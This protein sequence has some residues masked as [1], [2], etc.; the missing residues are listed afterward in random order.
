MT[1]NNKVTLHLQ[2]ARHCAEQ[3]I[4][5]SSASRNDLIYS[6]QP[7]QEGVYAAERALRLPEVLPVITGQDKGTHVGLQGHIP[8]EATSALQKRVNQWEKLYSDRTLFLETEIWISYLFYMSQ[9]FG[10][11][12]P[13][14]FF[15]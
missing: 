4:A 15:F 1:E 13:F 11:F 8:S 9:N 6:L 14:F 3:S 7:H 10:T 12:L 2:R 5:N